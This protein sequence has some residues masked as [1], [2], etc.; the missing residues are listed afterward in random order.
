M[1]SSSAPSA[2]RPFAR[3]SRRHATRVRMAL[4]ALVS[5]ALVA[6]ALVGTAGSATAA[7]KPPPVGATAGPGPG[8]T[9][10]FATRVMTSLVPHSAGPAVTVGS[11]TFGA[12]HLAASCAAGVW[13]L[14]L[15][16]QDLDLTST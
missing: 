10:P 4:T 1:S 5:V 8:N 14:Q 12:P 6:T 16:R 9:F 13:V 7:K 2:V 15:G 3:L 11:T